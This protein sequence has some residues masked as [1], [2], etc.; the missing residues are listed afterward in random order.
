M[1]TFFLT[2]EAEISVNA[3]AI[4]SIE[5][6]KMDSYNQSPTWGVIVNSRE[7]RDLVVEG[8]SKAAAAEYT[9]TLSSELGR[10]TESGGVVTHENVLLAMDDV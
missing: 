7:R 3:D 4:T 5:L 8:L 2:A 10:R 6:F 9:R 1:T